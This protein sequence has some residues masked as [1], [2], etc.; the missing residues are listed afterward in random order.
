MAEWVIFLSRC[1]WRTRALVSSSRS[2][3]SFPKLWKDHLFPVTLTNQ[4][5]RWRHRAAANKVRQSSSS[6]KTPQSLNSQHGCGVNTCEMDILNV[7]QN[8][9]DQAFPCRNKPLTNEWLKSSY[10]CKSQVK[11]GILCLQLQYPL[12]FCLK[13]TRRQLLVMTS[14]CLEGK[15]TTVQVQVTQ[16]SLLLSSQHHYN[17]YSQRVLQQMNL[18]RKYLVPI[19]KKRHCSWCDEAAI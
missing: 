2:C 11:D 17:I 4:Q 16:R 3:R 1:C 9:I 19:Y 5:T 10:L 6:L 8:R 15:N 14:V 13:T 12:L 7:E 18:M